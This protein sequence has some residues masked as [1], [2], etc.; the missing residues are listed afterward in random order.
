MKGKKLL[1]LALALTMCGAVG[2]GVRQM[3]GE[4]LSITASAEDYGV[5]KLTNCTETSWLASNNR[6]VFNASGVPAGTYTLSGSITLIRGGVSYKKEY[7]FKAIHNDGG[8]YYIDNSLQS[9]DCFQ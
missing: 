2:V 7:A 5:V 1:V 9:K 6:M 4:T 3:A 8:N